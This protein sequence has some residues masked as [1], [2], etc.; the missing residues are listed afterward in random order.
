MLAPT[1]SE[2]VYATTSSVTLEHNARS[3]NGCGH[4][5]VIIVRDTTATE[6]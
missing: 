5:H 2:M 6:R 1:E 4:T 3:F